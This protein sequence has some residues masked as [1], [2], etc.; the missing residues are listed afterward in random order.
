MQIQPPIKHEHIEPMEED[1]DDDSRSAV[2]NG[3]HF[4]HQIKQETGSS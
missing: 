3:H 2:T 4:E 1:D